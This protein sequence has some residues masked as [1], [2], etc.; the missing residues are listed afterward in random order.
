MFV[1]YTY[2]YVHTHLKESGLNDT[3]YDIFS[4]I[5]NVS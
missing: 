4:E 1:K 2:I 5:Y 3:V